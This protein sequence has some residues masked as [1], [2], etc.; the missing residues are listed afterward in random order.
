MTDP[1]TAF[2][3]PDRSVPVALNLV[4]LTSHAGVAGLVG[5]EPTVPMAVS[6]AVI[7]SI[8]AERVSMG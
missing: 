8:V 2:D 7:T 4:D 6:S 1:V 5:P 3:R